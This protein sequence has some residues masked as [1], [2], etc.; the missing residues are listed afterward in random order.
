MV[1]KEQGDKHHLK[2][3]KFG[4]PAVYCEASD[5]G[6]AKHVIFIPPFKQFQDQDNVVA[7]SGSW[8]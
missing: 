7:P 3:L 5:L 6:Y 4:L 2:V 8:D 1:E